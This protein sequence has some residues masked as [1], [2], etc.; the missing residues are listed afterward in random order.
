LIAGTAD[1][2]RS[3]IN[4]AVPEV[5]V[6]A[7]KGTAQRLQLAGRTTDELTDWSL[8]V[9]RADDWA[10]EG[11]VLTSDRPLTVEPYVGTLRVWNNCNGITGAREYE[12]VAVA[13][14][15]SNVLT[16][17]IQ[18]PQSLT[19]ATAMGMVRSI[20]VRDERLPTSPAAA[21]TG[22]SAELPTPSWLK[23]G[24]DGVLP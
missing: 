5:Y 20:V 24:G 6:G 10:K 19:D 15:G 13:R 17:Q 11:C 14:A 1:G 23:V 7:S 21:I 16:M 22:P 12:Y 4:F 8:A 18:A 3:S 9:Q 2:L